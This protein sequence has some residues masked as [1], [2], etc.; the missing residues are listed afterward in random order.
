[1]P[2]YL[3]GPTI[4]GGVTV[5]DLAKSHAAD[6]QTQ[7]RHEVRPIAIDQFVRIRRIHVTS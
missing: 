2:L 3:G 4:S 6:L 7:A 1:M 5:D